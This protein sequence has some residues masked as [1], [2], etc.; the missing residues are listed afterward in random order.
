MLDG[1]VQIGDDADTAFPTPAQL[2]AWTLPQEA[3]LGQPLPVDL[4]WRALGK[5]DAYYSFYVKL[6][7]TEGNVIAGWDGQPRDGEAPTLLWVPGE[8]VEDTVTLTI[9]ADATPGDYTVEVGMYRADDLARIL[10]LNEDSAPVD[11]V[12]LGTVRIEP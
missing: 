4:T 7:D 6:L 8:S 2:L 11:R 1:T 12:V 3:Q 10:T 9:P 5:I